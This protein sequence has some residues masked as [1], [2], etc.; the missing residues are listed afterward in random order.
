MYR[1]CHLIARCVVAAGAAGLLT[2][3]T[4]RAASPSGFAVVASP[5][6]APGASL[7]GVAA[8]AANNVWAV[9][10]AKSRTLAEHWTGSSWKVVVT[11]SEPI[12]ILNAVSAGSG[13]VWAVG[14]YTPSGGGETGLVERWTGTAWVVVESPGTVAAYGSV[15]VF[16]ASNVWAGGYDT[17]NHRILE[18]WNGAS[19][20]QIADD[21]YTGTVDSIG[22]LAGTTGHLFAIGA[23][24]TD[25]EPTGW[26]E[27]QTSGGWG[28]VALLQNR[29]Y[30]YGVT[31]SSPTNAWAVGQ[32]Q[33]PGS[34]QSPYAI[35][36]DGTSASE[37]DPPGYTTGHWL[38]AAV[39]TGPTSVWAV[40]GRQTAA[41]ARTLI[42]RYTASGWVDLGGPN[43]GTG[44]NVLYAITRVPGST[45]MWAVGSGSKHPLTL[46]HQ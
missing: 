46:R 42:D 1:L 43:A 13:S 23:A 40:G 21:G 39:T 44:N 32:H 36:W 24:T 45:A 4:A 6:I 17:A 26:F 35:R 5:K 22:G 29:T 9:G 38:E 3:G 18:H 12:S 2:G 15:K 14:H 20:T 31:A 19:W 30:L 27:Q 11:P 10:S 37:I 34:S 41:G 7:R 16:S 33:T 8:L 25:P 28:N